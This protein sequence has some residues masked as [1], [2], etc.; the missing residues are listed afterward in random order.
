[1]TWKN[2]EPGFVKMISFYKLVSTLKSIQNSSA[3]LSITIG[4]IGPVE[5]V[6]LP[7]LS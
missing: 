5:F 7:V 6:G 2:V 4:Q 3:R 1:M